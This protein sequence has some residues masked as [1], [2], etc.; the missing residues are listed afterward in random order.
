MTQPQDINLGSGWTVRF[1][2][3]ESPVGIEFKHKNSNKVSGASLGFFE[4][5]YM[6]S[7]DE[8]SAPKSVIEN[9]EANAETIYDWE[10]NYFER[11]PRD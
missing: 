8:Y 5:N 6:T 2:D 9:F 7:V 10:A 3:A 1:Q 11:N 4:Q